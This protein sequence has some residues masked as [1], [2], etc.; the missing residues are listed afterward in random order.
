M[1]ETLFKAGLPYKD[2]RL[3][4]PMVL[5]AAARETLAITN[6]LHGG[7]SDDTSISRVVETWAGVQVHN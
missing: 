1:N 6:L 3:S 7:G 2:I 4:V 5:R